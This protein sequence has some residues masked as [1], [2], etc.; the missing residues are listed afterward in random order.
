MNRL[1]PF[2]SFDLMVLHIVL[3]TVGHVLAERTDVLR[4]YG[5]VQVQIHVLDGE[6]IA[7]TAIEYP[8][9]SM[10]DKV[11]NADAIPALERAAVEVQSAHLDTIS[12][13]TWTSDGYQGS[14]SAHRR[15]PSVIPP[16]GS[17]CVHTGEVEMPA[18][19]ADPKAAL[20][21]R[22]RRVEGQVR[23]LARMIEADGYCVDVLTQ[24]AACTRA[25]EAVALEM[26]DAHLKACIADG[27]T[28]PG[29]VDEKIREINAAIGR[30][31]NF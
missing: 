23:G 2:W 9:E 15:R 27:A 5:P 10:V 11:L 20:L 26:L 30:L 25:L 19:P 7:A 8:Q 13:A 12:G 14:Q 29:S 17:L 6:I 24:V 28:N 1:V 18:R 16:R 3:I 21:A 22:L 4:A 31:V